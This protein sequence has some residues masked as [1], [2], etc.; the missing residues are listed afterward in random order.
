MRCGRC[1][2][3]SGT[4]HWPALA[5]SGVTSKPST[6]TPQQ[7]AIAG[8]GQPAAR[9]ASRF[10]IETSQAAV[11]AIGLPAHMN[12]GQ[13]HLRHRGYP[14]DRFQTHL[15]GRAGD[16]QNVGRL[17]QRRSRLSVPPAARPAADR[18]FPTQHAAN[19]P[20][21]AIGPAADSLRL[22]AGEHPTSSPARPPQSSRARQSTCDIDRGPGYAAARADA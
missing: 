22:P 20:G 18:W 12:I 21:A 3:S 15:A 10:E 5:A 16:L 11:A 19:P 6:A 9:G 1:E 14:I 8:H 7:P 2:T 13:L 4:S 17:G